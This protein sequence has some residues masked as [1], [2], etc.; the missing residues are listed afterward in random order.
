MSKRV[1]TF[2]FITV[3]D[4]YVAYMPFITGGGVFI[5]TKETFKIGEE[6]GLDLRLLNDQERHQLSSSVIWLTPIGAQGGK[7]SGIGLQLDKKNG[8]VLRNKIETHLAGKLK[9]HNSTNTM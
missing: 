9:S 7:P 4:L 1:I 2:D 6:V 3:N 8:I 5:P